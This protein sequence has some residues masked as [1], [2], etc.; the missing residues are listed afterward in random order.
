[1]FL[2]LKSRKLNLKKHASGT[3]AQM[4]VSYVRDDV[5]KV[6][7]G[8]EKHV[9]AWNALVS[10][11]TQSFGA[12]CNVVARRIT[13]AATQEQQQQQQSQSQSQQQQ[14]K[15]EQNE[16]PEGNAD[17]AAAL[18]RRTDAGKLEY[19]MGSLVKTL[20]LL[21]GLA[22][23]M[24]KVVGAAYTCYMKDAQK[25]LDIVTQRT[26][27]HPSAV[28]LL[29]AAQYIASVHEREY[30]AKAG[31][32]RAIDYANP[33]TLDVYLQRWAQDPDK[34]AAKV[35]ALLQRNK[36]LATKLETF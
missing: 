10:Q 32:L 17:V 33:E 1:M 7:L 22:D 16:C 12:L 8:L 28:D 30:W 11:S 29:E 2:I 26:A 18:D 5:Q 14:Q 34:D 3:A 27:F 4:S 24:A 13:K 20:D 15:Q 21:R 6:V 36:G 19:Y 31:I 23:Q 9:D 35:K 25:T